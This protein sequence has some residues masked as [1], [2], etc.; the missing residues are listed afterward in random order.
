MS[1]WKSAVPCTTSGCASRPGN[2]W[3][4]RDKLKYTIWWHLVY[5]ALLAARV[6]SASIARA[7]ALNAWT[8]GS[9]I[10][11]LRMACLH[12]LL[13]ASHFACL[14]SDLDA[15]RVEGGLCQDVF[16]DAAGQSPSAL[17]VLLRNV[18]PRPWLDVF[19]V[20]AVHAGSPC[21]THAYRGARVAMCS[22]VTVMSTRGSVFQR[23]T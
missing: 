19:A 20:L 1:S 5:R 9:G 23:A 8:S 15:A 18:H 3:F 22:G 2:Q 12:N 16:H 14:E 13:H 10:A 21:I 6:A 7:S 11:H 17:V 4:N